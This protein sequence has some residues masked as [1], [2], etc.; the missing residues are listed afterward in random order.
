MWHRLSVDEKCRDGWTCPSVWVD[1]TN[2]EQLVIVGHAVEDDTVPVADGET[3]IR[4]ERQIVADA[5]I[6]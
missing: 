1:D 5:E 3:A 6:R 2:P 4:I